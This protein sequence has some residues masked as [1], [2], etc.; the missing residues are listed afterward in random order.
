MQN[1]LEYE[2]DNLKKSE[3]EV[4]E[5]TQKTQGEKQTL[6]NQTSEGNNRI[7]SDA[8]YARIKVAVTQIKALVD[9]NKSQD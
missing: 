3:L 4:K 7:L 9:R 2:I 1:D 6:E 5:R 8:S